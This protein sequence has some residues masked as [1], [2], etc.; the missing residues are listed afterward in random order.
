MR[1]GKSSVNEGLDEPSSASPSN[2]GPQG[3]PLGSALNTDNVKLEPESPVSPGET[4]FENTPSSPLSGHEE[5][6]TVEVNQNM[7]SEEITYNEIVRT[8]EAVKVDKVGAMLGQNVHDET[9]QGVH[10]EQD[11]LKDNKPSRENTYSDENQ[12]RDKHED[13][14]YENENLKVE[15]EQ[16]K[17][18]IDLA[19]EIR[20]RTVSVSDKLIPEVKLEFK[21]HTDSEVGQSSNDHAKDEQSS[22][23]KTE[24]EIES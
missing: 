9:G 13:R 15:N 6:N 24:V 2:L 16:S 11:S 8:G 10:G 19:E 1:E 22:V 5:I 23:V 12:I 17:S 18:E 4:V 14:L 7:E 3:S 21:V 20:T